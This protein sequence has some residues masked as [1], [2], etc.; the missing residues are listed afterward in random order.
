MK[1]DPISVTGKISTTIALRCLRRSFPF[2]A[3][4]ADVEQNIVGMDFLTLNQ[5]G[6]DCGT[7][8]IIDKHTAV[9]S[10]PLPCSTQNFSS[11]CV[12][13][14]EF[15]LS[16][17]RL[18]QLCEQH[19]DIFDDINFTNPAQHNTTHHV[20]TTGP[21][22]RQ[23]PRSL[24][25]DKLEVAKAFFDQMQALGICR[26]SNSPY[27]SPLHMVPK[28]KPGDWRP[29]GD[30]RQLNAQ[31]KRD[32]YPLPQLSSFQFH[33]KR[34]FSKLDLVKAYHQIPV[35][36]DSVAKT[37]V[38]TPFGLFEFIR[39]PFGLRN[40]GQTF[41]R[42]MHEVLG[43]IPSVFVFVDDILIV[44]PDIESHYDTLHTVF[45]RLQKYGLR[46]SL[47]KCE[48]LKTNITFLGYLVDERGLLPMPSKVD[49]I[50]E[51]PPPTDYQTLRRYL[52]TFSFYRN[53]IPHF[54]DI[55]EP[56]QSLATSSQPA[57]KQSTKTPIPITLQPHHLQ[58]FTA[59]KKAL[60]DSVLLYHSHPEGR[61]S[62]TTDAS[63]HALGAALHDVLPDG[64]SRP[65]AFF[66]RRLSSCERN[67]SVFDKELLAI[68]AA[69]IKFRS[70]IEGKHT[71]VFTDHKPLIFA[72]R[73]QSSS[74]PRQARQLSLL[75]EY[76]DDF[77]HLSGKDNV[78]ADC[79][80]RDIPV[81]TPEDS[82]VASIQL[83]VFDLPEISRLQTADFCT[84]MAS[85]YSSGVQTIQV[86]RFP[87][88]CD[89]GVIPRPILPLTCRRPI[90]DQFHNLQH[91]NWKV[92]IRLVLARFTWPEAKRDIK[93]WCQECQACQQSKITRHTKHS[94]IEIS[95]APSRFSHVHMDVIGPLPPVSGHPYRYVVT[96]VDRNTRW[97]EAQPVSSITAESIATAFV[98]AWFSRFGTPLYLTTDR[99]T[100]FESE[101]FTHLSQIIGFTRLR[102]TSYH[103]QANGKVERFHR[104]LKTALVA[105]KHDWLTALPVVL[106]G[107]RI[108]KP[109]SGFSPFTLLTGANIL[110]PQTVINSTQNQTF[111]N[112][113]IN[114]LNT[115]LEL[116]CYEHTNHNNTSKSHI[117]QSLTYC[118]H[119]WLRTDR[120]KRPL[121]APY[122]GP[123]PVL[124][125]FDH[126]FEI[127]QPQG[128]IVVSID[129]LKPCFH[130]A[131]TKPST[132]RR[133][134][135]FSNT[136]HNFSATRHTSQSSTIQHD[137]PQ[138][139][140]LTV[141]PNPSTQPSSHPSP[142]PL[143]PLLAT[144]TPS[145]T[146]TKHVHFA[147][148]TT[149][150]YI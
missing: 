137:H 28:K 9:L 150:H 1:G 34:L 119:V 143:D 117:P 85:Q 81:T 114:T 62:L 13:K 56:L 80:S 16:D 66:S 108:A 90:F 107:Y 101:L 116:L 127:Q 123:F 112:E 148:H 147:P 58:A 110:I 12:A 45:T 111:T 68:H 135:H 82:S 125:R 94:P 140:P 40:A 138:L 18:E 74:S 126:T 8:T 60:A 36:P 19:S 86:G 133:E 26:P 115:S 100:Q 37:A 55:A 10:S 23:R 95:D 57:H 142:L 61:L 11:V 70:F 130:G 72:F 33:G 59:L 78:V 77:V 24:C 144:R 15:N 51:F 122:S 105:S 17:K 48:W 102:T 3:Y 84:A 64:T 118:S 65:L 136:P 131:S 31:T 44:T 89:T 67:Y 99:G 88:L 5:I 52:G 6:I 29:C 27:A 41:Q 124:R 93:S 146:R 134:S 63:D 46:L 79:L 97:C 43:D 22:I 92:T 128:P 121:E 49:A 32:C 103:P 25:P 87:L 129:R 139:Q 53:H 132:H 2:D 71:T 91:S 54:S 109:E 96:F 75:S 7:R 50:L 20:E 38:T 69:T 145:H 76:I 47:E 21:P 14:R 83:D 35:H 104:T 4:V 141:S 113:Y 73:K 30:Y 106:F 149:I 42:F 39:M 120:L 98:T